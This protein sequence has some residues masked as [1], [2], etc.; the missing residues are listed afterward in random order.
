MRKLRFIQAEVFTET[1]FGGNPV[2]VVPDAAALSWEEMQEVARGM[3][4]VETA[5]VTFPESDDADFCVRFFTPRTRV[6]FSGHPALGTA[7]VLAKEG[8]FDLAEPLTPVVAE[9]DIGCLQIDLFVDGDDISRVVVNE[10][11]PAFGEPFQALGAVAAGLNISIEGL[12]EVAL[13]MQRVST[14]MPTLIVPLNTLE[15]VQDVRPH[16]AILDEICAV[17]QVDCVLIYSMETIRRDATAHVRV[18][19][20]PLGVDEDPATG[21]ANGAL[22]AYLI[23]HHTVPV[24]PVTRVHCEQGFEIGRPSLVHVTVDT[25]GD[26]I[27][28][29][30]GGQVMRSVDGHIFF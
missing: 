1:P 21:S 25:T 8:R 27:R 19:A 6:R 9:T 2:V 14:G 28:V 30:V 7:Y 22:A 10:Q 13:P 3:A 4:P 5:F 16:Q 20:P 17:A 12:L 11:P 29:R 23:H 26:E 15:T 24:A 18:F